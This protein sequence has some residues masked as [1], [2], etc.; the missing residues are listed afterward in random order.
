MNTDLQVD[1]WER[2]RRHRRAYEWLRIAGFVQFIVVMSLTDLVYKTSLLRWE[3]FLS[4]LVVWYVVM[5]LAFRRL[6]VWPC[7]RCG[8]RF[9]GGAFG[10]RSWRCASCGARPPSEGD[11][12]GG[13]STMA[14]T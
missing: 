14:R 12:S 11:S 13:S 8:N 5:L 7:P 10:F 4:W 6:A 1:E 9:F 3:F 2:Y